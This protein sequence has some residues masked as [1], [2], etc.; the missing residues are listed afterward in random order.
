MDVF[1]YPGETEK[2]KHAFLHYLARGTTELGLAEH[3]EQCP[4]KSHRSTWSGYS[5][6]YQWVAR[7][8]QHDLNKF[9]ARQ[10][11]ID[12][13]FVEHVDRMLG[14]TNKLFDLY[15]NA[16]LSPR[17]GPLVAKALKPVLEWIHPKAPEVDHELTTEEVDDLYGSQG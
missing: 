1:D 9:E 16:E 2:A 6:K 12:E 5:H 8:R 7:K 14:L 10:A 15:E 17:E 4:V 13:Q 11:Y 3:N